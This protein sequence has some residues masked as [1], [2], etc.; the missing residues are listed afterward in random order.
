VVELWRLR[1][2]QD[3]EEAAPGAA[4]EV[5]LVVA[6]AVAEAVRDLDRIGHDLLHRHR[7]RRDVIPVREPRPALVPPDDRDVVLQSRRG[8]FS[9][10]ILGHARSPCRNSSTGLV[11]SRLT[12]NIPCRTPWTSMK[13]FSDRLP[14]TGR[15]VP[16]TTGAGAP[17]LHS[18]SARYLQS[19]AGFHWVQDAARFLGG[20]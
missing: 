4:H 13:T 3:A 11:A 6:E 16:S 8:A 7:R 14:A 20:L 1:R 9:Q 2:R 5:D 18:A 19:A 17:L 10:E 12:M 15:R